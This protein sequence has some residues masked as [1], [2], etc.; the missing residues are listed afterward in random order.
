MNRIGRGTVRLILSD[1]F[2]S[3]HEVPPVL[4]SARRDDQHTLGK[5]WFYSVSM[6]LQECS[7][8]SIQQLRYPHVSSADRNLSTLR[9]SARIV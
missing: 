5:Y 7:V 1:S 9:S 8:F 6:E 2:L 3:T 4:L